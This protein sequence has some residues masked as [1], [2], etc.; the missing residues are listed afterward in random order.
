MLT[1][2]LP[3]TAPDMDQLY[4][5]V[6]KGSYTPIPRHYST[7]ASQILRLLLTIKPEKRPTIN[8]VIE[9]PIFRR[10]VTR[11][12]PTLNYAVDSSTDPH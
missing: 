9:S 8:E 2:S 5:A 10:K 11:I 1:L 12:I 6:Q 7:E 3:F 4:S